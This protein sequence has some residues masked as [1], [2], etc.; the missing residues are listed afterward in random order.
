[1][2]AARSLALTLALAPHASLAARPALAQGARGGA[3]VIVTGEQAIVPVPTLMEG[4][5]ARTANFDVADQL[6]LRLAINQPGRPVLGDAGFLPQLARRW[7]RRDSLTLVFELDDRARWHDGTPVT[8]GDLTFTFARAM[9]P[10]IAASLAR[11]PPH[12]K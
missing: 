7:E 2:R 9:N 4:R 3:I 1:M 12:V 11:P 6:F 5:A 8:A 10:A